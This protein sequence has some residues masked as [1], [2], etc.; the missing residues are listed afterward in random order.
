MVFAA[1]FGR[2]MRPLP[3]CL[4][5]PL[6]RLRGKALIDHVL[7]RITAAKI[8]RTIVNVHYQADLIEAH[9]R[10]RTLPEIELSNERDGLLDTGGGANK[11]LHRLGPDAFLTHNSDS[12]WVEDRESNLDRLIRAWDDA[13]MDALLMLAPVTACV[14]YRGCGDFMLEADG[15]I[16]RRQ[17]PQIVPFVYAGVSIA[18]PRLFVG[19]P[20]GAFSLNLLWDRA[21]AIGRASGVSLSGRWMHVDTPTA[22]DIAERYFAGEFPR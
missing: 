22:L 11:A 3:N 17:G 8:R 15:R 9:L 18:H 4:P 2:R 12:V 14:G 10:R 13:H 6:V 7:D 1:G 20:A 16:R 5:K 19:A 21:I